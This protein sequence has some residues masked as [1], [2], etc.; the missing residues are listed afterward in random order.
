MA[1]SIN[2][3]I[4]KTTLPVNSPDLKSA[5][6]K[7]AG[8]NPPP[9]GFFGLKR[10]NALGDVDS[11]G[12][13]RGNVL[14]AIVQGDS[15]LNK[16]GRYSA[17]DWLITND[18]TQSPISQDSL[19]NL[20]GT[21]LSSGT[22]NSTSPRIRILDKLNT[23]DSFYGQGSWP[24][25]HTGPTAF[26]YRTPE[27]FITEEGVIKFTF[28][29]TTRGVTVTELREDFED[30]SLQF[31]T[32]DVIDFFS[33]EKRVVFDLVS[34]LNPITLEEISLKGVDISLSLEADGSW[35]VYSSNS[36]D[37]LNALEIPGSISFGDIK[38]K[39]GRPI[40]FFY[41]PQWFTEDINSASESDNND[42]TTSFRVLEN[43]GGSFTPVS[44]Q[45]YWYSGQYVVDRWSTRQKTFIGDSREA[46]IQDSNLRFLNPPFVIKNETKN[47]GV[48]WDG[49]LRLDKISGGPT[50]FGFRVQTNS[51]VKIDIGI[52]KDPLDNDRV[53]W[54]TV[55]DTFNKNSFDYSTT[56]THY[57]DFSFN[58]DDVPPRF[59]RYINPSF[60][61][62]EAYIPI[63][64]RFFN[65]GA[66][67]AYE[68][69][70]VPTEPNL[71][72]KTFEKVDPTQRQFYGREIEVEVLDNTGGPTL[73]PVRFDV[74]DSDLLSI[75]N[76][77][78]AS[79]T[80]QI[81]KEGNVF[82]DVPIQTNLVV[83]G[84]DEIW[85]SDVPNDVVG[86][87]YTIQVLPDVQEFINPAITNIDYEDNFNPLWITR[88]VSPSPNH[89]T[90]ADLIDGSFQPI[91]E[92]KALDEKPLLWKVL[93][94]DGFD[95][96]LPPS[97][98]N[99]PLEGALENRFK[100]VLQSNAENA[101][102]YGDGAT[103]PT[104]TDV[105]NIIIGEARFDN[106]DPL[107]SNYSG[108]R[109][110]AN[111]LGEGGK[112][113]A[114]GIPFNNSDF[115]NSFLLG[116]NDLGGSPSHLTNATFSSNTARLFW[117]V[118]RAAFFLHSNLATVAVSD[119]PGTYGFPNFTLP[120]GALNPEW[121][122]LITILAVEAGDDP[123]FNTSQSFVAPLTL[124][125]ERVQ[126]S[127]GV[128]VLAFKTPFESVLQ[129]GSDFANFNEK[130]I[131]YYTN[132]NLPY[133][134]S[135][136]DTG[137]SIS[138]S[139][140]LK[141]TYDGVSGDFI[142]SVS[143]V[144]RPPADRV[145]PFG[146]DDPA[147]STGICYPPYSINNPLLKDIAV[148]DANLLSPTLN[149]AGNYDVFWGDPTLS[150]LGNHILKITEKLQFSITNGI[151]QADI[152]SGISGI[153]LEASDY[154]HRLE[155]SIPLPQSYDEDVFEHIGNG[156]KVLDRYFLFVK[157][158]LI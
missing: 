90:Y 138:L 91:L 133:F 22:T 37:N 152:I 156:E 86:T 38:F 126:L 31:T 4:G 137:E 119:T 105:P 146:Y 46:I 63:S 77:P 140:V 132:S 36:V 78:S 106:S 35:K 30:T 25:L 68:N 70:Q 83:V 92:K 16:Y 102:F 73:N 32:Q 51:G 118:S 33:P 124:F 13:A 28:N 29:G 136:V 74:G 128:N 69:F 75:L 93:I 154:T 127:P 8:R 143:E 101:G 71:F 81:V 60:T 150:N 115:S 148:N 139:D 66:D 144:P 11:P 84:V 130:Y 9:K 42:P 114:S 7:G 104:Y 21:S 45:Q 65:G 17:A 98:S 87:K 135:R 64:I 121:L 117:D 94:G 58:I 100:P 49:Y 15:D 2:K 112:I 41:P 14:Q 142:S 55:L 153:T 54:V 5:L 24:G 108:I 125:V 80:T 157:K 129:G 10:S 76:N 89:Q 95:R 122:S 48:R 113:I 27:S 26:F 82:V 97:A 155:V 67:K 103:P 120:G 6:L 19:A 131:K 34:Y 151:N 85:A 44:K 20:S 107:G 18:L 147:Y 72:I 23:F 61:E 109:F 1:T 52:D 50:Q 111:L 99:N 59:L 40:S 43:I 134:Y 88:I 39:F 141:L 47:W 158:Q 110:S 116:E 57:S 79:I 62:W 3:E 145:T 53:V 123:L 96:S 12:K 56:D 149:P